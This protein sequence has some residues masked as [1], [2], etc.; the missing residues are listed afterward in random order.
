MRLSVAAAEL[1]RLLRPATRSHWDWLTPAALLALGAVGV[2]FIYSAQHS[3]PQAA[4]ASW[5]RQDWFKQMLFLGLG[6]GVYLVVS[7]IDY[8][9]W[10]RVAHGFYLLC[11]VPLVIVLIPGISGEAA[12]RWGA[13]R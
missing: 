11:L 3:I 7:L 2:A 8:R 6:A 12:S 13:Q 10:L 4:T 5:L 9:F 1:A